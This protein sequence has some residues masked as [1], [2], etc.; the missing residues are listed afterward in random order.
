MFP[1]L[2]V[3]A[4][5]EHPLGEPSKDIHLVSDLRQV[6]SVDY[7]FS[8]HALEHIYDLDALFNVLAERI[9]A[10]GIFIVEVPNNSIVKHQDVKAGKHITGYHFHFFNEESLKDV[11][12]RH[13]FKAI[14]I[15][16]YGP[17]KWE[18]SGMN[19]MGVFRQ[20]ECRVPVQ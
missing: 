14:S 17:R 20:G 9:T 10:G 3:Y 18:L 6:Q 11:F 5:D 2:Y 1:N 13:N 8:T 19:L 15:H 4:Y 12:A 16:E 7:V